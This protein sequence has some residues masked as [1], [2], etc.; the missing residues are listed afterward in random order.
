MTL[1]VTVDQERCCG[2]GMCALSAPDIFDQ[3]ESDGRVILRG[4]SVPPGREESVKIASDNCP[5][6][7]I[8]VTE[9]VAGRRAGDNA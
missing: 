9:V 8:S 2:S 7:A 5:C 1:R 4:R 3:R 6:E